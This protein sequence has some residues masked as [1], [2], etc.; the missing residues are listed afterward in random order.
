MSNYQTAKYW[1]ENLETSFGIATKDC[2]IPGRW[3]CR[4]SM[5]K[6]ENWIEHH[7]TVFTY[8]SKNE[9]S[10]W[11]SKSAMA[12]KG[13]Q[14]QQYANDTGWSLMTVDCKFFQTDPKMSN[15]ATNE[16]IFRELI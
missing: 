11:I 12:S 8:I 6:N 14:Q 2:G 15:S 9:W 16:W 5:Q 13:V 10:W 4:H 1:A 3:N 7:F